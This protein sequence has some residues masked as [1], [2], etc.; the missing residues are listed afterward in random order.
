M[1]L[2][3]VRNKYME[4]EMTIQVV[5]VYSSGPRKIQELALT[6]A[7]GSTLGDALR[8]SGFLQEL[9]RQLVDS[10]EVG[11]WGRKI[12]LTHVLRDLDRVEVYRPLLVD[13][14]V[15]RRERFVRQGAKS[16]GLFSKRRVGAKA[17]Y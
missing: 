7:D 12:H 4:T 14:K 15:A 13:P 6:L 10:L 1:L 16:A 9:P 5:V 8:R 3:S 2:S 11:V 17:G